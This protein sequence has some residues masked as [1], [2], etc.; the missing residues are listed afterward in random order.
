ML[1]NS[2]P[3]RRVVAR[4]APTARRYSWLRGNS[5]TRQLSDFLPLETDIPEMQP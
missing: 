1:T 5:V 3:A 4:V 2:R